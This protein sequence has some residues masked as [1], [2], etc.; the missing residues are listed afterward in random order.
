MYFLKTANSL[1]DCDH[2]NILPVVKISSFYLEYFLQDVYL[3]EAQFNVAGIG[4][5][6][7]CRLPLSIIIFETCTGSDW[8][9]H[10]NI[11]SDNITEFITFVQQETR[12]K[13]VSYQYLGRSLINS[14]TNRGPTWC[15]NQ[16][17]AS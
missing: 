4:M 1:S 5:Y 17:T 12:A 9:C 10:L 3:N 16:L 8:I 11:I 7:T 6:A 15:G 2:V 14:S 13:F